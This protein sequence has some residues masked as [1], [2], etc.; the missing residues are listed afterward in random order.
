MQ[1]AFNRLIE[2]LKWPVA[3]FMVAT[4]PALVRSFSYFN[5]MQF[6]FFAMFGGMLC[7]L[8]SRGMSDP[9]VKANMQIIA[10][11][12]T[13]A[14]FAL[15]TLHKIKH[16]KVADD[17]SGGSMSF[18]GEGNWLII[19]APYFFPLFVALFM[20]ILPLFG[21]FSGHI[22][23]NA[24]F[25]YFV[26]YHIDTVVSQ[27]HEKQTDLPKVSYKFC[28]LFLPGANLWM[29][30]MMM[31]FNSRLWDGVRQYQQLVLWL[32]GHDW[33]NLQKVLF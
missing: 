30:G 28:L 27:I 10:H 5:F 15:M 33:L 31:A 21:D 17:D 20:L 29:L 18:E 25:G 23:M 26:A 7:Y 32:A 3:F 12:T 9:S 13:H 24:L 19:I 4:L 14:L 1:I 2:M 11:E 6:K 8:I 22:I 16:I